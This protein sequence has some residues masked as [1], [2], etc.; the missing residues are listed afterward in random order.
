M[1][2]MSLFDAL[3]TLR[4]FKSSPTRRF[5]D[6]SFHNVVKSQSLTSNSV[7]NGVDVKTFEDKDSNGFAARL[8]YK[9]VNLINNY[10]VN[11]LSKLYLLQILVV[12]EKLSIK[13]AQ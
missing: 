1:F 2:L 11:N 8:S 9:L 4:F 12:P 7:R 6:E 5:L 3:K 13:M 10:N